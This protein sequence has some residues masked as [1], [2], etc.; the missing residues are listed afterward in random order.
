MQST[1]VSKLIY[2]IS[3]SNTDENEL[4][5]AKECI[6]DDYIVR[7]NSYTKMCPIMLK[8]IKKI[9]SKNQLESF[10]LLSYSKCQYK[11]ENDDVMYKK[12]CCNNELCRYAHKDDELKTPICIL[13]LFNCCSDEKNCYFDH[14]QEEPPHIVLSVK[15]YTTQGN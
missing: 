7:N 3:K 2:I 13:N 6:T 4:K 14:K 1:N 5:K 11:Y 15:K 10:T 12:R 8:E 9:Q